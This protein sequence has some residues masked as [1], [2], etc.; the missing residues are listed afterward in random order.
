MS[1]A[2]YLSEYSLIEIF[3]SV[4]DGDKT[5]LLSIEPDRCL[6][7][8]IDNS[9]RISFQNGRIMSV[10]NGS[11]LQERGLL[12]M[13]AQRQW[14]SLEQVT[15]LS[16]HASKLGQPLGTYLK[17]CNTLDSSQLKL[18][19][20]AQVVA[21]IC[22]LFGETHHGRFSF[23]PQA[24][25]I[26]TEMTGISLPA[27]EVSLL[28][29]RML[30]DWSSLIAKLPA[31]ESRIQRCSAQPPNLRLDTQE[32][33]VWNLALGELSIAQIA[34]QLGLGIDKVR[35][36]GFRLSAIGLVREIAPPVV[37]LAIDLDAAIVNEATSTSVNDGKEV[38]QISASFLTKLIGFLKKNT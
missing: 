17:S 6:S 3:N 32:S 38:V 21:S 28:G 20:D 8:S 15:G 37:R 26:Y 29:L 7:R 16:V 1:L 4:E 25:L 27:K 22:K 30:R 34:E 23:D 31:P 36:I 14:L 10:T 11:R 2:G 9:Y 18:L 35:Q 33:K 24:A 19:F 13:M 12:Q 5:G